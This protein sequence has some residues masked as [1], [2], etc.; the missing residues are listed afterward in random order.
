MEVWSG[1]AG[2]VKARAF[3]RPL[4]RL[5]ALTRPSVPDFGRPS[6]LSFGMSQLLLFDSPPRL[7]VS[8]DGVEDGDELAHAGDDGDLCGFAG[9][10]QTLVG[11]EE[12]ELAAEGDKYAHEQR[13]ADGL[14]APGNLTS[15]PKDA[16]VPVERGKSG[17][18][19]N[20]FA[21]ERAEF[22]H[23][24]HQYAGD[25]GTDARY[26]G[27]Q[28]LLL[29]PSRGAA[30]HLVDIGLD[31]GE[32]LLKQSQMPI[33]CLDE[34]SAHE[35]AATIAFGGHHFDEL[36]P[37][38][39]KL[40]E[41][42]GFFI[43]HWSWLRS[44]GFGE[45]GDDLCIECIRLGKSSDGPCEV[46]DLTRID[47]REREVGRSQGARHDRFIAAGR[48]KNDQAGRQP[49]EPLDE[50]CETGVITPDH[51]TLT[52]RPQMHIQPILGNIDADKHLASFPSLRMR[53][54]NAALATVRAQRTSGRSSMLSNGL[55][56]PWRLRAPFRDRSRHL[57]RIL[58]LRLDTRRV[59][60]T[61]LEA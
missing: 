31:F 19:C 47:D 56:S 8:E 21:A 12:G 25:L 46:P 38:C 4:A 13:R 9:G 35:L 59:R 57:M 32:L 50:P 60:R 2:R 26:A 48:L 30:H 16:A 10:T 43:G 45:M 37:S 7:F 40:A 5:T 28:I 20:L 17:K 27:E 24:G 6:D 54:R 1:A 3:A 14:S 36:P 41:L 42:Q 39:H 33:E 18:R 58:P 11:L 15:S 52:A 53:A 34:V 51:K 49:R 23:F 29:A 44:H 22:G 61:R 55:Q